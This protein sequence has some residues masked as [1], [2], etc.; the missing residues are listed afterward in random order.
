LEWN[1]Q[2]PN[3]RL[4]VAVEGGWITVEGTVDERYQKAAVD[5][6][7]RHLVGTRGVTNAIVVAPREVCSKV[8]TTIEAA[9]ARNATLKSKTVGVE[10]DGA[11][12]TL[13]G[14]VHSHAEL[15][16]A[17]RIAWAAGGVLR[18]QNCITLTPWGFGPAEE[19]GY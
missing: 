19:W 1:A 12:V 11:T 3:E 15:E 2:V 8:K 14:D 4:Q 17:E 18:V 6:A 5:R 9:L 10:I 7:I 13:T 16:E